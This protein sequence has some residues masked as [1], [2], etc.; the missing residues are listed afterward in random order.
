MA[1]TGAWKNSSAATGG[2]NERVSRPRN[3]WGEGVDPRHDQR[4]GHDQWSDIGFPG[5]V[6]PPF[7]EEVPI[8][9][10]DQ[11][12]LSRMPPTFEAPFREPS[13]HD[14]VATA[15]W[16][17][18]EW[19]SQAANNLA[20]SANYG[21]PKFFQNRETVMRSIT[22]TFD[23]QRTQSFEAS[24]HDNPEPG[25]SQ[26]ALRGKNSLSLNNPG[27]AETNFSGNYTRAG[28][29]QNRWTNRWMPMRTITHTKRMLHLNLAQT[30][31][32]SAAPEGDSYSPYTSPFDGRVSNFATRKQTPMARREP[33]P[34]DEDIT[35]DGSEAYYDDAST[36]RSWGL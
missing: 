33:R 24:T 26:R 18:G 22:Q 25:Q 15:P 23:S 11:Y 34:W 17:V 28:W 5:P 4:T 1:Y 13:G 30:A 16:G 10:E 35:T 14:G 7:H 29:E 2:E 19:R 6:V 9:L 27:N 32:P 31:K 36:Y 3:N 12:D 8:E 21:M 20:R